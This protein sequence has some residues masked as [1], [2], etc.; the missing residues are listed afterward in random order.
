MRFGVQ[1]FSMA[2][3]VPLE[4]RMCASLWGMA[5]LIPCSWKLLNIIVAFVPVISIWKTGD[6]QSVDVKCSDWIIYYLAFRC[7]WE[8][9]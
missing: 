3:S 9:I 5:Q 2:E 1:G 6:A 7:V 8:K 4:P